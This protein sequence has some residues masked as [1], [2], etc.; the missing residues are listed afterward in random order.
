MYLSTADNRSCAQCCV[1]VA[2][3]GRGENVRVVCTERKND[4]T[5][6][7]VVKAFIEGK[8]TCSPVHT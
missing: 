3:D 7:Y 2:I 5:V 4:K 1:L 8:T 6:V